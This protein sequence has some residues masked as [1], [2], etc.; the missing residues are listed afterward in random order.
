MPR[1]RQ[2]PL[3]REAAVRRKAGSY[4]HFIFLGSLSQLASIVSSVFIYIYSNFCTW[5]TIFKSSKLLKCLDFSTLFYRVGY[6]LCP[7][8][9]PMPGR[10]RGRRW[11]KRINIFWGETR[12]HD[13]VNT[14]QTNIIG[15]DLAL[16][17]RRLVEGL[18]T[19]S[20]LAECSDTCS[21]LKQS[22]KQ[23]NR[24]KKKQQKKSHN[25]NKKLY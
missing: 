1:L 16:C 6:K 19:V 17:I 18:N 11:W 7:R 25:N 21:D 10:R 2:R 5:I 4:F 12:I 14:K 9:N 22:N 8:Y 15:V 24:K 20:M 3:R 13:I 23:T